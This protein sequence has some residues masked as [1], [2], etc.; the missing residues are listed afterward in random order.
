MRIEDISSFLVWLRELKL[1][2]FF[3]KTFFLHSIQVFET[4]WQDILWKSIAATNVDTRLAMKKN[5]LGNIKV[6]LISYAA[7]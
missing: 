4:Y 6:K 5:I 3:F 2:I 1:F 7:K